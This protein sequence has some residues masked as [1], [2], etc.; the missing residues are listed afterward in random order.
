MHQ[1]RDT[2]GDHRL[3]YPAC[4]SEAKFLEVVEAMRRLES[5][6]QVDDGVGTPHTRLEG[7]GPSPPA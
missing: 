7:W 2:L 4:S 6:R 3:G 5:P 1:V